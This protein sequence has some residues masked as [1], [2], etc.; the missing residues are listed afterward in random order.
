MKN[1]CEINLGLL[2]LFLVPSALASDMS[3]CTAVDG[4][5][6]YLTHRE[7]KAA[8]D[9]RTQVQPVIPLSARDG[10]DRKIV[11]CTSKNNDSVTLE[12][13]NCRSLDAYQQTLHQ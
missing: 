6:S 5:Y 2:L 11:K 7:C 12:V 3:R 9:I 1:N 10:N 13:G 8:T 4:S